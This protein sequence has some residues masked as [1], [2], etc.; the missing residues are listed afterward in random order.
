MKKLFL[1][2]ALAAS[3][4]AACSKSSNSDTLT[5]TSAF[6]GSYDGTY[7]VTSVQSPNP[8]DAIL[9]VTDNPDGSLHLVLTADTQSATF[10]ATLNGQKM[11]ITDQS[12]FGKTVSG[13]GEMPAT[14]QMIL[15][16]TENGN[17]TSPTE[18]YSSEFNGNR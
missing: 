13:Y 16:F 18:L 12:V 17:P 3:L 8:K 1:L 14:D 15:H 2:F 4:F 9:V 5:P 6:A 7:I 11:V 10:T